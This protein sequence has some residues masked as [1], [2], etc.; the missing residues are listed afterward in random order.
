MSHSPVDGFFATHFRNEERKP[1]KDIFREWC[2]NDRTA[3]NMLEC[4]IYNGPFAFHKISSPSKAINQLMS[5]AAYV[6]ACQY[7]YS[8]VN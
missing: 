1:L 8:L 6:L 5:K 2:G 3:S 7:Y 4:L